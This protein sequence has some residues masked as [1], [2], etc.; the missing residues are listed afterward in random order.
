MWKAMAFMKLLF[1]PNASSVGKE[2]RVQMTPSGTG[3]AWH[4][5]TCSSSAKPATLTQFPSALSWIKVD[6]KEPLG[7]LTKEI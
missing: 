6:D 2:H 3:L 4:F 1:L 5:H 7:M